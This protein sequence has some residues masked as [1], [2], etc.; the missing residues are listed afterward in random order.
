MAMQKT[1]HKTRSVFDRYNIV[2]DQ[3]FIKAQ[4]KEDRFSERLRQ[5]EVKKVTV[6]GTVSNLVNSTYRLP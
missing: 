5:N 2:N 1:G 4:E 6:L 3:D